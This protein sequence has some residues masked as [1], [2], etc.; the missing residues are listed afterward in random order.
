MVPHR[1][2]SKPAASTTT[3]ATTSPRSLGKGRVLGSRPQQSQPSPLAKSQ[4]ARQ[5][6]TSPSQD[7]L[8]APNRDFVSPSESSL[9]LNSQQSTSKSSNDEQDISA[10]MARQSKEREN[11]PGNAS[12]AAQTK[13]ACPICN[14][15]MVTLLQ[16]NRHLDDTHK[17]IQEEEQD[18]IE[19]W[20]K[21]QVL[22]AKKFQ[23]LAALNQKLKGLDVFDLNE[24]R[25]SASAS[26]APPPR[27]NATPSRPSP[28]PEL[29]QTKVV[30][31]DEL[32]TREHWQRYTQDG[33][34][35]DPLC[36][37]RLGGMDGRVNCRCCGRLFCE[38]HTMYQLKLSRSALHEPIRGYWCRVCE[39]C[40]KSREGYND[41][42]G[43][44]TD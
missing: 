36:N 21:S 38:E 23:P 44:S 39:T 17:D 15:E 12:V 14:E 29:A 2:A 19:N 33:T 30:D 40:Y 3:M 41:H 28:A 35:S 37:R 16:L 5:I 31:P 10:A 20:F 27:R 18:E 7:T 13:L 1:D 8:K 25:R 32:V 42:N 34:C 22:K 24:E 26:P 43:T 9:S 4:T 11:V 6:A